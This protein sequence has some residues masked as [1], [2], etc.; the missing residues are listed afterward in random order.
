MNKLFYKKIVRQKLYSF[1]FI[2]SIIIIFIMEPLN[3]SSIQNIHQQVESDVT[4]FA[5]GSYDL[6]V[7]SQEGKHPLEEQLGMVPENYI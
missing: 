2:F 1:L 6:L 7:R 5:R 4:H 3:L